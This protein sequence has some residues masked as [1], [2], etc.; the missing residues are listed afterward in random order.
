M[1][2]ENI[3]DIELDNIYETGPQ[4]LSAYEVYL[5]NGGTLSETEWLESLKGDAGEQGPQ[6]PQGP[7]GEKGDTGPQG[8]QGPQGERGPQGIQ[9]EIGPEGPQGIQGEPG[10]TYTAGENITIDEN[11]VISA[12]V[13]TFDIYVDKDTRYMNG[14]NI[15]LGVNSEVTQNLQ[16]F[17]DNLS[18]TDS[19]IRVCFKSYNMSDGGLVHCISSSQPNTNMQEYLQSHSSITY[20]SSMMD[21]YT[22]VDNKGLSFKI[23]VTLTLNNTTKKISLVSINTYTSKYLPITNTNNNDVINFTPTKDYHPATKKYVDDSLNNIPVSEIPMDIRQIHISNSEGGYVYGS[24]INILSECKDTIDSI[25]NEQLDN[26]VIYLSFDNPG[27]AANKSYLMFPSKKNNYYPNTN[28]NAAYYFNTYNHDYKSGGADT[29]LF[30]YVVTLEISGSWKDGVFTTTRAMVS[31]TGKYNVYTINQSKSNFL[32]KT[33]TT[34]FTPTGDY[35][36]STKLYTDKTH[37]ENM[38]GYDATKT[39]VLKNV[40]G[41]LTWVDEV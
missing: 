34:E 32:A 6:G 21:N 17:I 38:T 15:T 29:G 20:V 22:T 36:P 37:Y 8:P 31:A 2:L 40:N 23:Y 12:G 30:L 11:N 10:P 1:E 26:P 18:T 24:G 39:Q 5:K 3:I 9:G 27:V 33:N 13:P 28:T 4:G 7:Q 41:T 35:N 14:V 19:I 25:I 16:T